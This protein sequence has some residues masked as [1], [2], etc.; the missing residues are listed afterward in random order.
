[1]QEFSIFSFCKPHIYG[2]YKFICIKSASTF[3]E[4]SL[5]NKIATYNNKFRKVLKNQNKAKFSLKNKKI[6]EEIM[7]YKTKLQD[8]CKDIT[9]YVGSGYKYYKIA[10]IPE[11]KIYKKEEIFKK[12]INEYQTNLTQ[13][14]R[15]HKR[16]KGKANYSAV[17]F[18]EFIMILK[19]DGE[20]INQDNDF[21]EIKSS[22]IALKLTNNLTLILFKDN[23]DKWTFRVSNEFYKAFKGKL[24]IAIK[25]KDGN[26]YYNLSKM[27]KNLPVFKGIGQQKIMLNQY[28]KELFMKHKI[29]WKLL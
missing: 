3:W 27:W 29:K 9:R 12:V 15:Q 14:Q 11:K 6:K 23:R 22:G 7:R 13:G 19:T 4:F 20:P 18:K 16:V 5:I 26:D 17:C 24:E 21:L 2:I 10:R 1:M 25:N 28:I 8:F